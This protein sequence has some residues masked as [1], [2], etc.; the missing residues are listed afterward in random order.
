MRETFL[1]NLERDFPDHT[2]SFVK[3]KKVVVY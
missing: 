2:F 3:A 1:S